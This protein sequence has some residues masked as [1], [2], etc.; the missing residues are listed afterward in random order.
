MVTPALAHALLTPE[1]APPRRWVVFLHG[2]LGSGANWR[3]FAKQVLAACPGWGAALVDL[4]MHGNSQGFA[5]PHTVRAA[6]DDLAALALPGPVGAVVAHSFGG[7]VALAYAAKAPP[8][9]ER[10]WVLDASPSA[11]PDARG[12]EGTMRVFSF[13]ETMAF[14][15][16]SRQAFLDA[17]V[18]AGFALPFAQWLA[19][20]LRATDDG[21]RLRLDLAAVRAMLDDYLATDLWHVLEAPPGGVSFHLVLGGRSNAFSPEDRARAEALTRV[22]RVELTVLPEADHWVHVDDPAGLFAAL[23]PGLRALGG[24]A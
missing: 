20:N 13:L 21:F 14:P 3:G 5:P 7:K 16:P 17:V 6:A 8:G 10:A 9:L 4:R 1:G 15:L 18:G 24:G 23:V 12:S 2:I 19:M 11:R 22:G